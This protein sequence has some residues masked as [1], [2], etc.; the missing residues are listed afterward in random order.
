MGLESLPSLDLVLK[1]FTQ[2][3]M[4]TP[5]LR[6]VEAFLRMVMGI[7]MVTM[8]DILPKCVCTLYTYTYPEHILIYSVRVHMHRYR[9]RH[10]HSESHRHRY[11]YINVC[12][13]IYGTY[14]KVR[15]CMRAFALHRQIH[16]T[17]R[18]YALHELGYSFHHI[19]RWGFVHV[20]IYIYKLTI[21]C[22]PL[23]MVFAHTLN[24]FV[25]PSRVLRPTEFRLRTL[26]P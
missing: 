5:R 8:G 17:L 21:W 6:L 15:R 1:C 22:A 25:A 11:R 19:H 16:I 18:Y 3:S 9:Y 2:T 10:R 13:H 23:M 12:I 4:V 24:I 14:H 26:R 7:N 20:Y